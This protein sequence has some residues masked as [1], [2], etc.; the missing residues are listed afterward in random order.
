MYSV[1]ELQRKLPETFQGR[2]EVLILRSLAFK[3]IAFQKIMR[4]ADSDELLASFADIIGRVTSF[5]NASPAG[6]VERAKIRQIERAGPWPL[7]L[8]G[9]PLWSRL[10]DEEKRK[11]QKGNKVGSMVRPSVQTCKI[12]FLF[13]GY[14]LF[15]K[16]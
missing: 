3:L 13:Y 1:Q 8:S 12:Y 14:T 16:K 15:A 2:G 7:A 9:D 10:W 4:A 6:I 5:I 11:L